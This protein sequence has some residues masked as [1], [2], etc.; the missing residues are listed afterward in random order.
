MKVIT[1][2]SPAHPLRGGI[3]SSTERLAQELQQH[4][5]QVNIISFSL[6][7]PG[8]LFPGKTQYTTDPAPEGLTI[9]QE[10]NSINPLNWLKIGLRL[11]R[12]RPD[13]II[14]RFWLPF[15]GPCLGAIM[16]LAKSNGHTRAIA[17]TDNIIPHE[18]RFG[19]RLF[20]WFFL[21]AAD[22]FLVMSK[23]VEHDAHTLAPGKPVAL[24]PHPVYDNYGD[25]IS[26]AAALAHLGLPAAHRY[27]LFF[28]FIR[29]YKGLDL[30]LGAMADPRIRERNIRLIVAGEYYGN[31]E[32]Y[33][34]LIE[35]L[36]IRDLLVL[37]TDYIPND[38]VKYYFSA[39]DLVAQP[40]RSATQSGISQLAYHFE[41]PMLATNVGGLP[42]TV[43]HGQS[44]YIVEV[45]ETAIADAIVD[46]Y[47]Q[48]RQPE[49]TAWVAQ[50]K[51]QYSWGNMVKVIEDLM[52]G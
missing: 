1:L 39:A 45:N 4:G 20:T 14:A 40:Y 48:N 15:M 13:L 26:R 24:A 50:A 52:K 47:D 8:F 21:K 18:R 46:F 36:G 43:A 44:G 5:Y 42:E 30:L 41:K 3:A 28:G 29:E 2:L 7:Y 37:Q 10:I 6:Q 38:A 27:L 17:L 9:T 22:A 35:R 51:G 25:P 32:E 19:D 49:M 34:R 23:S 11:R 33:E 12:A 31:Q 16:R